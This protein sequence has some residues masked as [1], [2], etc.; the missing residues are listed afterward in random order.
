VLETRA[1]I[2][3]S[4]S[5]RVILTSTVLTSCLTLDWGPEKRASTTSRYASPAPYFSRYAPFQ[6]GQRPR[7]RYLTPVN[8][9]EASPASYTPIQAPHHP[10]PPF[11][12]EDQ[13]DPP[14]Q[15]DA[16]LTLLPL[17]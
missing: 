1:I 2:P 10:D 16:D 5:T 7:S 3:D 15:S 13:I 11:P 14:Q 9:L 17:L 8:I 4:I 12:S 6:S